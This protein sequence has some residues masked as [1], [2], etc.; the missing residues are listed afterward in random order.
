MTLPEHGTAPIPDEQTRLAAEEE[1]LQRDAVGGS[2]WTAVQVLLGLPLAVVANA[3]VAHRLGAVSYGTL[4]LYTATFGVAAAI[5]NLG[6]SSATVQWIATDNVR[7]DTDA[8]RESVRRCSGYHV[9]VEAPLFA[10]VAA[11][12]LRDAGGVAVILGASAAAFTEVV[13]TSTVVQSGMALNALAARISIVATVAS[14]VTIV[15]VATRDPVASSVYVGRTTAAMVGPILAFC[16]LPS[17]IRSAVI[18][19]KLTLRFPPGFVRFALNTA[20][21]AI[22]ASLVFGR[23]ELFAFQAFDLPKEAGLFALAAGV[24]ALITAPIDALLGPLLPAATGLLAINPARAEA[25]LL[26]GLRT[27]ALLAGLVAAVAI[28]VVAPILPLIYGDSFKG[29]EAAYIALAVVSCVASVNHPVQAFLMGLKETGL[30]FRVGL[31]SL[32]LDLGLAFATVSNFGI[33]GAVIASSVAQLATLFLVAYR[34]AHKLGVHLLELIRAVSYFVY[35]V[36]VGG[37]A[38]TAQLALHE[39]PDYC[40]ALI[41]LAVALIATAVV[42]QLRPAVGLTEGDISA[43]RRGLPPVLRPMFMM[44]VQILGLLARDLR[45]EEAAPI[46]DDPSPNA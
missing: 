29:A 17:A 3:V 34:V 27:S 1:R 22:V 38:Y 32:V 2:L 5:I 21:S 37:V 25:A 43:I 15:A 26:R 39:W 35:A 46:S 12:I 7:G 41:A 33:A 45:Q 19:P 16:L 18:R 28:P 9:F 6:I 44:M 4:A 20:A 10:A 14:Q 40:R 30:L 11:F 42:G 36:L 8:I 23:S 24:A 31:C 13:G